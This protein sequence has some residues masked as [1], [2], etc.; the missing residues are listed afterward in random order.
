[1]S[2]LSNRPPWKEYADAARVV[3]HRMCARMDERG[4]ER[5]I[6]ESCRIA[7][8]YRWQRLDTYPCARSVTGHTT[9]SR[10]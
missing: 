9:L 3:A 2:D 6:A 5:H 7:D 4:P 1:M 8:S 10:S